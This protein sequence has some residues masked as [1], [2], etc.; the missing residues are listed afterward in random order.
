[1]FQFVK[2]CC[3][4][5]IFFVHGGVREMVGISLGKGCSGLK[6]HLVELVMRADMRLPFG[7][8]ENTHSFLP[9]WTGVD[10]AMCGR[11]T[12]VSDSSI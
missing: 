3:G 4:V 5:L 2:N 9:L 8:A 7:E 10:N 6:S 12:T 11:W 1:M